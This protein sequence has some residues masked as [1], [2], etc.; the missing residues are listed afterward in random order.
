MLGKYY[1][2]DAG[3]P[4]PVGYLGPYKCERY[5]LLEFSRSTGF[6]SHNEV[7]NYFHSSLRGTIERTFGVWKNRFA[8]LNR[9]P[10]FK[11]LT[12][13]QIVIV[14]MGIHNFIRQNSIT[15]NGFTMF[16]DEGNIP[17][18]D[19][20]DAITNDGDLFENVDDTYS[21]YIDQIQNSIR[22]EVVEFLFYVLLF[23]SL[24]V[25]QILFG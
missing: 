24:Y 18:N 7:F 5:H 14:T 10:K 2:V 19:E 23:F 1:L 20:G 9:M 16:D 8:I 13:V 25:R 11:Y 21:A 6:N 4:T 17:H 12:Q 15:D 3:Y 22:D